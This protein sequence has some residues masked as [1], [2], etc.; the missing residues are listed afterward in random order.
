MALVDGGRTFWGLSPNPGQP[1][2]RNMSNQDKC[3]INIC[4]SNPHNLITIKT[5]LCL[6]AQLVGISYYF[7]QRHLSFKSPLPIITIKLLINKL[8]KKKKKPQIVSN[9]ETKSYYL[10]VEVVIFKLN[11][12]CSIRHHFVHIKIKCGWEEIIQKFLHIKFI[13]IE[14]T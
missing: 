12:C 5:T 6:V 7:Q 4:T 1:D 8:K 2:G 13:L 11:R 14:E 3:I 10:R 9:A